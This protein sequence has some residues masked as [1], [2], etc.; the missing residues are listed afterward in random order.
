MAALRLVEEGEIGL[1]EEQLEELNQLRQELQERIR[2]AEYATRRN[3]RL[4]LQVAANY[5]GRW[6]II[7][8]TRRLAAAVRSGDMDPQDIDEKVFA[9]AT[10]LDGLPAFEASG[11]VD[12]PAAARFV[13]DLL[14]TSA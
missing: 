2:G 12:F 8:A 10:A 5:G 11:G 14:E 6:D 9:R 3:N 7:E 13:R 4:I 1:D